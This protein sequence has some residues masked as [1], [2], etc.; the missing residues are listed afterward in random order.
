M[1]VFIATIRTYAKTMFLKLTV[2]GDKHKPLNK[3]ERRRDSMLR[4]LRIVLQGGSDV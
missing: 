2:L 3:L 4:V 1:N